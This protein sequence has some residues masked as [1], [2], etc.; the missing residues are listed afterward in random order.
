MIL[1]DPLVYWLRVKWLGRQ[2]RRRNR[3]ACAQKKN[4]GLPRR[5]SNHFVDVL[6]VTNRLMTFPPAPRDCPS[7]HAEVKPLRA[8]VLF[9]GSAAV[10]RERRG[11]LLSI[12]ARK[13]AVDAYA[14]DNLGR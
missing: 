12:A 4:R 1:F 13:I 5:R 8:R 2:P 6:I 11:G 7:S 10:E 9:F 14:S 3:L